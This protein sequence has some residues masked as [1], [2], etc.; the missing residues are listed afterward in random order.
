MESD[1]TGAVPEEVRVLLVEDDEAVAEMYKLKLELDGYLVQVISDGESAVRSAQAD[2]PD[3]IFLDV[4]LPKM[5]GFE[6]LQALRRDERTKHLPVVV[7][8]NYGE[9]ELV[10]RGL[11]LGALEYLIKSQTTPGRVS[12]GV[13]SWL[14]AAPPES[15]PG[16]PDESQQR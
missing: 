12:G 13:P 14:A 10:E 15:G 4:R 2:P 8:S 3:L 5:D 7:L 9:E 11:K 1:D 6:V 16:T